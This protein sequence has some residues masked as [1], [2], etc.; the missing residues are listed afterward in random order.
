MASSNWSL[1]QRLPWWYC[2]LLSCALGALAQISTRHGLIV[3]ETM[4][5][6]AANSVWL[7]T[8]ISPHDLSRERIRSS[9]T[10][11]APL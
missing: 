4:G 7:T 3:P 8:V 9:R 10:V 5:L 1:N 2:L 11:V 6:A